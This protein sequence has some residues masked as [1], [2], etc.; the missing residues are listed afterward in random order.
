MVTVFDVNKQTAYKFLII[1]RGGVYGNVITAS[2]DAFGVFK[3]RD[4]KTVSNNQE[5][6]QSSSTL[7]IKPD[8]TFIS[9]LEIGQGIQ[10]DG[11]D[12][13]ITGL[14]GGDNYH[15]GFREHYTATLQVADYADY[16]VS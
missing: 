16:E 12:Y 14:T 6:K 8:E 13:E 5:L 1:S 2:Y 4:G 15:N 3:L 7:H 9:S 10:I 11:N